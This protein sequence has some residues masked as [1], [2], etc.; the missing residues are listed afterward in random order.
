MPVLLPISVDITEAENA[1]LL[2]LQFTALSG[3]HSVLERPLSS[4]NGR[5]FLVITPEIIG[6]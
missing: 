5:T 4:E 2:Q 1:I 3:R 6:Y